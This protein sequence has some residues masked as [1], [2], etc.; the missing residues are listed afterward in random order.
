MAI[1]VTR[2]LHP[3]PFEHLAPK[4]F[5]D[6]VRQLAYDFRAW[7]SLEA[8]GRAG[9]DD[10]FDARGY[11]IVA[12][13]ER[14][15]V[16]DEDSDGESATT[17]DR[18]WLIQCKRE[19]SIGPSKMVAHLEAIMAESFDGLYGFIFA[20]ACDFSKATRDACR[21]WCRERGI[22]EIHIWGKAEIEDQL[23]QP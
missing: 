3:L 12:S 14:I 2:T 9:S 8:T 19:R 20:A 18:L 10:G 23:Y 22:Q 11:E 4:R 21:N 7:R 17:F 13:G 16:E 6:L 1:P 15:E 5:E